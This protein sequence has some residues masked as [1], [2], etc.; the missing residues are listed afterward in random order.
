MSLHAFSTAVAE[1][2]DGSR[3]SVAYCRRCTLIV[4]VG[5]HFLK[6]C[7]PAPPPLTETVSAWPTPPR[8]EAH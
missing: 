3:Q 4:P 7:L 1:F 8:G 2:E 5:V 6:P